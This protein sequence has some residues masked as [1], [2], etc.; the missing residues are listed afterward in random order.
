MQFQDYRKLE[1]NSVCAFLVDIQTTER[2]LQAAILLFTLGFAM[3][4]LIIGV[5]YL[6]IAG[7][8]MQS[9][10]GESKINEGR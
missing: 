5:A 8:V 7:K 6:K 1:S 9:I 2:S 10:H 4:V 3:P